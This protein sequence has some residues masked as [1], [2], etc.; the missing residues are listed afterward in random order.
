MYTFQIVKLIYLSEFYNAFLNEFIANIHKR[1]AIFAILIIN[2]HH[3]NI[4][5]KKIP[6]RK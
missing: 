2:L 3:K 1:I 5:Q 4:F 6:Q